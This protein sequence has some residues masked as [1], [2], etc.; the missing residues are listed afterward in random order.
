M[1]RVTAAYKQE[2][3]DRILEAARA[4]FRQ[5]GYEDTAMDAIAQE[6]G[7]SKG[8]LYLYFPSKER[9]FE[10]LCASNLARLQG[11]LERLF[12]MPGDALGKA[13]Q[14]Y[15]RARDY[16]AGGESV[17]FEILSKTA[18]NAR[19]AQIVRENRRAHGA[20]AQNFLRAGLRRGSSM[21][22]DA[23]ALAAGLIALYDGLLVY[24]LLDFPDLAERAWTTMF[25]LLAQALAA[26]HRGGA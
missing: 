26:G 1:P 9:L 11:E 21:E 23:E 4:C 24:Q 20:L 5:H 22:V 19:L 3:R 12:G 2:V 6:C 8:T 18:R 17:Y 14:F 16:T 13:A 25:G 15:A 7:V 10:A